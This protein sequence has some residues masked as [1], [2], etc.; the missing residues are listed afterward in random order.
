M[1]NAP[2]IANGHPSYTTPKSAKNDEATKISLYAFVSDKDDD[3]D[4]VTI[5]LSGVARYVAET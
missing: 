5:N 3:V 4:Y 1:G 2:E